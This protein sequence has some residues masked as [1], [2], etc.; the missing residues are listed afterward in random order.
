MDTKRTFASWHAAHP[1]M[2]GWARAEA[3]RFLPTEAQAARW[4]HLNE[5]CR[6]WNESDYL[7]E[8][9]RYEEWPPSKRHQQTQRSTC[10]TSTRSGTVALSID[11]PLKSID[12]RV[13]V[14][15][16]CGVEVPANGWLRCPLPDHDDHTPSFQVLSSHWRCFGCDRGGSIIDL[17]AALYG[18]EPRGRG[19]FRLRDRILEALVWAPLNPKETEE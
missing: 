9:R 5:R 2:P 8:Q 19:Y 18:I 6:L 13:Y 12:P 4:E 10:A 15:A 16:L 1:D 3:F 14:E 17:A 7:L 11:D